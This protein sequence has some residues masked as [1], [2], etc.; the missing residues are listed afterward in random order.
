MSKRPKI[1]IARIGAIGDICMLLPFV[2]ALSERYELHWLVHS[3]HR[4]LLDRF[5]LAACRPIPVEEVAAGGPPFPPELVAQLA[6]EGYAC[7][8]D[9]SHWPSIRWL[10]GRLGG[11]PVRATTVD[12]AQDALLGIPSPT[13]KEESA[14]NVR[15]DVPAGVHQCEK[16]RLLIRA[17]CHMDVEIAWPLPAR[18][19]LDP[20]RPLKLF[21][22]AHAG[23]PEKIWPA[24]RFARAIS[25]LARRRSAE[26]LVNEVRGRTLR[27]LRWRFLV[28]G[29]PMR[30]IP[31]DRTF[32]GLCE[33]LEQC[34]LAIGCDSGPM[35]VAALLGVPTLVVYGRYGAAEFGPL[36][37]SMPVSPPGPGLD[38]DTVTTERVAAALA[39]A[40]ADLST[41]LPADTGRLP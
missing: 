23:K 28:G 37:R 19:A 36:W 22:H 40:A 12:P 9:F 21:L 11:I 38:A 16:W 26:C 33:T 14:F 3:A 25:G 2:H 8:I 18:P 35:H 5:P 1:L 41:G 24:E 34:D 39:R 17:A 32:R 15:V 7:L 20:A 4:P 29:V 27:S 30:I 6:G 13:D 10:A 31:Q